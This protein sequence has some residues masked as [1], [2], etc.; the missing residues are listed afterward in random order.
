MRDIKRF[1]HL[2]M[3]HGLKV[4]VIRSGH[5]GVYKAGIKIYAFAGTPK[6]AYEAI[7][8]NIKDLV[9]AG[10]LPELVYNGKKYKAR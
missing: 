2:L 7:D 3:S 10:H 1:K 8:N 6:N 9:R 4:R 5:C